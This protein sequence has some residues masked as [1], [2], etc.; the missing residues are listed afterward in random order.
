MGIEICIPLENI[1][2][3]EYIHWKN[4]HIFGEYIAGIMTFE[5]ELGL[6]S[7]EEPNVFFSKHPLKKPGKNR[8]GV[9]G[10]NLVGQALLAAIK[11]VPEGFTPNSL[12]SQFVKNVSDQLL[13]RWNVEKVSVGKTFCNVSVKAHQDDKLR[14]IAHVS[15]TRRNSLAEAEKAYYEYEERRTQRSNNDNNNEDNSDDEEEFVPKPFYFETPYPSW[16][17][18]ETDQLMVVDK[19]SIDRYIV[20]KIPR[21]MISLEDT[22][23]EDSVPVTL[24]RMSFMVKLGQPDERGPLHLSDNAFQYVALGVLSDLYFLTRLARMLRIPNVDLR[25]PSHYFSV[26]LDH[27]M[28]FHDC[29]FDCTE[30]MAF[31]FKTVRL[32]NN[33]VLLEGEMYNAAGQHVAT[34]LQEGLVHFNGLEKM[35]KL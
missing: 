30:W 28:Y 24:R 13:V 14:F 9:Y 35:V 17:T 21:R 3:L 4:K 12:H 34:V 11:S 2:I 27:T 31:A 16:L 10:G 22:K 5:E 15:L 23:Y 6:D 8:R 19:R 1:Q 25:L 29:S 33:R 26:S 32:V 7:T 18:E 20:H